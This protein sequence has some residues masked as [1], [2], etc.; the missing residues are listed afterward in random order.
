M[1]TVTTDGD[2]QGL[3]DKVKGLMKG[4]TDD[5][6]ELVKIR[7]IYDTKDPKS[8][9][10]DLDNAATTAQKLL[11]KAGLT[12]VDLVEIGGGGA[13]E[14]F[15]SKLVH[16]TYQCPDAG[17]HTPTV[18]LYAHYDVVQTDETKWPDAFKPSIDEHNRLKGRGAA[19]DKSGVM[20]HVGTLRALDGKPPV[21]LVVVLEG[22]E[23]A[24]R[25]TLEAYIQA[26]PEKF[27]ADVIIVADGGN[28]GLGQPTLTKSLRGFAIVDVTVT[29]LVDGTRHSGMFGGPAGDAFMVLARMLARLHDA[30]GNVA[31]PGLRSDTWD[32]V[33]PSEDAFRADAGVV[34]G[35]KLLGTGPLGDR[36]YTRPSIN[37]I[38]LTSKLPPHDQPV[39]QLIDTVTA[40]I[41][42]R[43]AP[44]EDPEKAA[45]KLSEFLNSAAVNPWG[46]KVVVSA[47]QELGRG[48]FADITLPGYDT[49][50][51][52][53]AKAYPGTRTQYAGQGGS[54]PLVTLLQANSPKA[55][56]L[57]IGCEEPK[58]LIHALHES[59][60]LDELEHMTLAQSY[61]LQ[62][63]GAATTP[64][65]SGAEQT[66]AAAATPSLS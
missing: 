40:R 44:L 61:L 51:K 18:L 7:S 32:G 6:I 11:Q 47:P 15:D 45:G 64:I 17:P 30:D 26:H 50:E 1:G 56:V 9:E 38:G 36:L 48:F 2:G 41:G 28:T 10:A 29:T 35:M 53:L 24:G 21:N 14:Q 55:V 8:H 43:L 20:M 5:L 60:S 62:D 46:A 52:A 58:C 37:V 12:Q 34:Q 57:V 54:I 19:D 49:A 25:G 4:I 42:M 63:F 66:R 13:G 16:G 65:G 59:V 22:E 27:K 23:E 39:N 3:P 33:Q 31:V